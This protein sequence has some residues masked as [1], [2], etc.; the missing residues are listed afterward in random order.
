MARR[1]R[2]EPTA[3]AAR[4]TLG[5]LRRR[6]EEA[7]DRL[8]LIPDRLAAELD[9]IANNHDL[10]AEGKRERT[11][12]A[13]AQAAREVETLVAQARQTREQGAE[14]SQAMR[15]SRQVRQA[16]RDRMR[17]LLE[18]GE[19]PGAIFQRALE[20]GAP[21]MVAAL[22]SELI[23]RDD[24]S[25]EAVAELV[26]ECDRALAQISTGDEQAQ[27]LAAV[28]LRESA[29]GF[30]ELAELAV[31]AVSGRPVAHER[32][33]LGLAENADVA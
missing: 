24:S 21:E 18:R 27:N 22:R 11:R 16:D 7:R 25:E 23:W 15:V 32:I 31:K 10:P 12:R 19:T 13:R 6:F 26:C 9:A 2:L 28:N 5:E 29:A 14:R 1:R 3:A 8:R 20:L 4:T 33:R 17:A 30:D